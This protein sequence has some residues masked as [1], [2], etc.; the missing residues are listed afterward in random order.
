MSVPAPA[1]PSGR[2]VTRSRRS[3]LLGSGFERGRAIRDSGLRTQIFHRRPRS[4]LDS[5]L[6]FFGDVICPRAVVNWTLQYILVQ[7]EDYVAY[8]IL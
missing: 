7:G 3:D 5:V 4:E 1:T 2:E 6:F 8:L